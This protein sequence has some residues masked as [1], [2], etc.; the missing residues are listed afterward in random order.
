MTS[1]RIRPRFYETYEPFDPPVAGRFRDG[2]HQDHPWLRVHAARRSRLTRR[3]WYLVQTGGSG[4]RWF[5]AAEIELFPDEP[6]P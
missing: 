4:A 2:R 6:S 1:T 5:P 3:T